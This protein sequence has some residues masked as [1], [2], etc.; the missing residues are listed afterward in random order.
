MPPQ[1]DDDE[2]LTPIEALEATEIVQIVRRHDETDVGIDYGDMDVD[3]A[4]ALLVRG[5]LTAVIDD[6][7]PV[8][9][10]EI[11]GTDD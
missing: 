11:D 10:E 4:I 3:A 1:E 5:L 2:E 7:I 6:I 8:E 9:D